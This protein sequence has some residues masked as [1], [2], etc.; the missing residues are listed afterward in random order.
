MCTLYSV[1]VAHV[2]QLKSGK[3][4]SEM[5]CEVDMGEMCGGSGTTGARM[6]RVFY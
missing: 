2:G 6:H 3:A 4:W 1:I 5:S